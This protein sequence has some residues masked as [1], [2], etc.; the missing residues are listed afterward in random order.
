MDCDG[1]QDRRTGTDRY[2]HTHVSPCGSGGIDIRAKGEVPER[3]VRGVTA[4]KME[5]GSTAFI[6]CSKKYA[7]ME[8]RG[9]QKG[10]VN[11]NLEGDPRLPL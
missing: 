8:G 5:D 9:A 1:F 7:L 10:R 3:A 4:P 6:T 2:R 11:V